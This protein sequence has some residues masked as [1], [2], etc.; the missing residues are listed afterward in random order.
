MN[1][2]FVTRPI[3]QNALDHLRREATVEVWPGPLP[4]PYEELRRRVATCDGLLC[5]LTDRVDATLIASAPKLRVISQMAVGYDNIDVAAATSRGIPVGHTPG[6][7]TEATADLTWALILA[8]ARRVVEGM[9]FIDA[10]QWQTWDPLGLLGMELHGA[11]LGILGLGRIGAAVA[12]RAVGFGMRLLYT[13]PREKP[14]VAA[15]VGAI[16]TD[17][18]TLLH[19]SDVVSIHCPLTPAT[20]HLINAHALARMKPGAILVN[21]ARGG[22]VDHAALLDALRSGHLGGAGLDVTEPEPLPAD[23]PLMGEDRVIITPHIGSATVRTRARMA[24][25]AVSNLLAGL[26]GDPLPHCVNPDV[27][28]R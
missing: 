10:G 21:T 1:N 28:T 13:G 7:L 9:R 20:R 22:I 14:D 4:P 16:Y 19:E 25:M 8:T 2:V 27:Y 12:R 15:G 11:T 3:P 26:R 18:D 6:V 17:V 24:D 23:H 5:L